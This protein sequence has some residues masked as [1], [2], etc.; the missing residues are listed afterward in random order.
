MR[1]VVNTR[2][3]RR[4]RQIAQYAFFVT[5]GVLILGLFVTN[6]AP[7]NP[8]LLVAPLIVL[9]VGVIATIYSVRMANL[10][11]REPRPEAILQQ[12]LKGQSTR[13]VLYHYFLPARH[14]LISPQGV[15]SMTIRPQDGRFSIK[16]DRW[17]RYGSMMSQFMTFF[18][19]DS[20]GSPHLEAVRDAAR[21]QQLL[22][23]V[24]PDT[25]VVVQPLIVMIGPL[26][27]VEVEE[28]SIPI[29]YADSKKKPNL[30]TFFKDI[31]KGEEAAP[32]SLSDEQI[33]QLEQSLGIASEE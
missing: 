20:V 26:V 13:S 3:V 10:W 28:S 33:A 12:G 5:L 17:H 30:K 1:V 8:I 2:R 15:F 24:L 6:A 14:L 25:G 21:T 7:N 32:T 4:N 29:L 22:D 9:P 18:R 23:K 16:D 27:E 11:L 31:K 19:Q